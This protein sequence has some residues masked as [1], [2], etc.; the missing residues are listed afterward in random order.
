M[1]IV[2]SKGSRS[3]RALTPQRARTSASL[4]T[5]IRDEWH[6]ERISDA[7]GSIVHP[8]RHYDDYAGR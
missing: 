3:Y 2:D 7:G 1:R 5:M 4:L 8:C 6:A